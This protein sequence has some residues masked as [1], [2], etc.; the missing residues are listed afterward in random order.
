MNSLIERLR[1][2]TKIIDLSKAGTPEERKEL[3]SL[4]KKLDNSAQ[5]NQ[6]IDKLVLEET[7]KYL[8]NK[9]RS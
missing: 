4:L 9:R 8:D 5:V 3:S 2:K 1:K 7:V 6:F